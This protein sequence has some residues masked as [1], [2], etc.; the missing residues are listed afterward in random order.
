MKGKLKERVIFY[1][2]MEVFNY[3]ILFYE[4]YI[5]GFS[6]EQSLVCRL[7]ASITDLIVVIF[8]FNNKKIWDAE[9]E[10]KTIKDHFLAGIKLLIQFPP[11]YILKVI[12]VN[13]L[14]V[15]KLQGLGLTIEKISWES[16]GTTITVA[17]IF[18]LVAGIAYSVLQKKIQKIF[19]VSK[20]ARL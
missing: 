5:I 19:N 9:K 18:C 10:N 13:L 14:V 2:M 7:F 4:V 8:F 11:I 17:S 20:K 12:F 6:F 3:S 1:L 15:P 16:I